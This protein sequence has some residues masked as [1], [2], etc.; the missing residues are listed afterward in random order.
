VKVDLYT[1]IILT[2]SAVALVGIL[3]KPVF[4]P[5]TAQA[6]YPEKTLNDVCSMLSQLSELYTIT[7]QIASIEQTL[8]NIYWPDTISQLD[9]ISQHVK[10]IDNLVK[11]ID[12][13]VWNI[14]KSMP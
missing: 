7:T 4:T 3:V 1:K 5:V 10:S 13:T 14:F 6:Y 8:S 9:T 12:G 2:I 11:S